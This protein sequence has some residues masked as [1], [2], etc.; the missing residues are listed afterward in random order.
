MRINKN[1]Y[2]IILLV[3]LMLINIPIIS[4]ADKNLDVEYSQE[5]S[6]LIVNV[7]GERNRPV[8]IS[9]KDD[10][11]YYFI[12]QD[13]TNELGKAS[14]KT[15]LDEDKTYQCKVN[16]DGKIVEKDIIMEIMTQPD[17][18]PD[19]PGREPDQKDR[20][21]LYVKGY[22]GVILNKSSIEIKS[23][24]SALD[25][26]TRLLRENNIGYDLRTGYIAEIDGQKEFD[27][28]SGSGW[29]F[30]INGK[31]PDV[32]ASSV[33]LK[34][35]DSI[36]WLYTYD[37]GEDID[38]PSWD[39]SDKDDNIKNTKIEEGLKV[40]KNKSS[41]ESEIEQAIDDMVKCFTDKKTVLNTKEIEKLLEDARD[42]SKTLLLGI[43]R[44]KTEKLAI[45]IVNNTIEI[46]KALDR[47]I[48]SD[49]NLDITKELRAISRENVGIALSVIAK[50]GNEAEINTI[51]DDILKTSMKIESRVSNVFLNPNK[52]SGKSIGINIIGEKSTNREIVLPEL[53]LEK[54][55]KENVNSI[56]VFSHLLSMEIVPDFLGV[57]IQEDL[58]MNL[59]NSSGNISI[60]FKQGNKI[61]KE[62]KKPIKITMPYEQII[63]NQDNIAVL[64]IL[65]D[66]TKEL[67][68]GRYDEVTKTVK[69]LSY[70]LG[71]FKIIENPVSFDDISEYKWAKEAINT[72]A[73]KGIIQGRT[74]EHFDPNANITRAEFSA[75]ISRIL[76]LN[77][78]IN[79]ELKFKDVGKDKWYYNAISAIYENGLVSGRSEDIFDPEG[80]ITREE[81]TKIIGEILEKNLYKKQDE[82][83][84]NQFNDAHN[85]S[86]WAKQGAAISAHN[87]LI[88]GDNG[89]FKPRE[90]ATRVET[91]A[92]LHKLYE[93]IID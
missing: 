64:I 35:G 43:D 36:R 56:K 40:I 19:E 48:A 17:P 72:M 30:S 51:I 20:A 87:K 28:G 60:E 31:Y 84:L 25:F 38:A 37:L 1:K 14:F 67:L 39:A 66:G 27:K 46:T 5:G 3:F 78:S 16:I 53:L 13:T 44:I 76:K 18:D 92:I 58:Q 69:F 24:E 79:N 77:E 42:A 57:N 52:N 33:R 59:K 11:R 70:K 6:Q 91:V 68:G 10:F 50:I 71:E 81:M 9:I 29:M 12:N 62:T 26:T 7:T 80:N 65:E 32:G 82:K 41:S 8:S 63:K 23:N 45:N 73:A 47:I 15:S 90:D 88:V 61:L 22:K 85:I 74:Q 54:T 83:M 93:L 89:K 4:M 34:N 21:S 86:N 2:L 49:N 55:M 75:L